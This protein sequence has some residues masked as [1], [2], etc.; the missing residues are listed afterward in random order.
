VNLVNLVN[1]CTVKSYMGRFY[2]GF[3]VEW[4]TSFTPFTGQGRRERPRV[5][6]DDKNTRFEE[7]QF[8]G[9]HTIGSGQDKGHTGATG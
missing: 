1:L 5:Q 9:R 4:F 7:R 2:R 3:T 8:L 6:V